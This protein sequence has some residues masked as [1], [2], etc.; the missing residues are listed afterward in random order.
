MKLI[1]Y[2]ILIALF[3]TFQVIIFGQCNMLDQLEKIE[4]EIEVENYKVAKS[5]LEEVAVMC[6]I[7]LKKNDEY[8]HWFSILEAKIDYKLNHDTSLLHRVKIPFD[9]FSINKLK[10]GEK[11][12]NSALLYIDLL[13]EQTKLNIA[14]EHSN[15]LKDFIE[16]SSL[17]LEKEYISC[18]KLL[19]AMLYIQSKYN[20]ALELNKF[21]ES[22]IEEAQLFQSQLYIDLKINQGIIYAKLNKF[23]EAQAE[24]EQALLA[25][26]KLHGKDHYLSAKIL[27]SMGYLSRQAGDTKTALKYHLK[28]VELA[29]KA[30]IIDSIEITKYNQN[31]LT[32]YLSDNKLDEALAI[33]SDSHEILKRIYGNMHPSYAQSVNN[34]GIIYLRKFELE[35]AK[36]YIKEAIKSMGS[37]K[38][39]KLGQYYL[40]LATIEMMNSEYY[41]AEQNYLKVIDIFLSLNIESPSLALYKNNLATLYLNIGDFV[42]AKSL[43]DEANKLY[44]KIYGNNNSAR[45]ASSLSNLGL[46]YYKMQDYSSAEISFQSASQILNNAE[47]L[48]I[49]TYSNLQNNIGLLKTSQGSFNDAIIA[50][51]K[52]IKGFSELQNLGDKLTD[53]Y[54]PYF[55]L[56]EVYRFVSKIDS[57]ILIQSTTKDSVIIKYGKNNIL[58]NKLNVGL[59]RSYFVKNDMEKMR[60]NIRDAY[61]TL[62][63]IIENQTK[64][65][66]EEEILKFLQLFDFNKNVLHSLAIHYDS[67]LTNLAYDFELSFKNKILDDIL[68]RNNLIA[69]YP[70][71]IKGK[72]EQWK[73]LQI[74]LSKSMN[75]TS[76]ERRNNVQLIEE[77]TELE[78]EINV[79]THKESFIVNAPSFE[80]IKS[81]LQKNAA[82]I[83][84]ISYYKMKSDGKFDAYKSYGALILK[85]GME[86]PIPVFLCSE[87]ALDSIIS[88][89][90]SANYPLMM[91]M[92]YGNLKG[93][94]EAQL[95]TLL[96]KP[97]EQHL[98]GIEIIS[99]APIDKLNQ[100]NFSAIRLSRKK[101]IMDV[102]KIRRLLSTRAV[103]KTDFD[104][105]INKTCLVGGLNY[106]QIIENDSSFSTKNQ[107]DIVM[108]TEQNIERSIENQKWVYLPGSAMEVD[109]I[110]QLLSSKNISST[111]LK[112][113]DG[114]EKSFK[115]L[116]QNFDTLDLLHISTHGFYNNNTETFKELM[117]SEQQLRVDE[118]PFLNAGL[119]FSGANKIVKNP[120]N[121]SNFEE[122]GILNGIEVAQMNLD[123]T[124]LVVLS[125]C[126]SGKGKN[127]VNEGNYGMVRAF[128]TAGVDYIISSLWPVPDNVTSELMIEFYK[129]YI[130]NPSDPNIALQTAQKNLRTKYPNPYYWAAFVA[131]R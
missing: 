96:W 35:Q 128:K 131:V 109:T 112:N 129:N 70:D 111:V 94:S 89:N 84:F 42:K 60:E 38:N 12:A 37:L 43:L 87:P 113:K 95:Y 88:V 123:K 2:F 6:K 13:I 17:K 31:I 116:I 16:T 50:F 54:K 106:D 57:S 7:K 28:S 114:S 24:T 101:T 33:A 130:T 26:E 75:Q 74:R 19:V 107:E 34:L 122:D 68:K 98:K 110:A 23:V 59:V 80:T 49:E 41:S 27:N 4:V 86:K 79:A 22:K 92:A 40:N 66:T 10:Y 29:K 78:K 117:L 81:N 61:A 65:N 124:K 120:N 73:G 97:M 100:I 1:R 91:E 63:T 72:Y 71:D 53:A 127:I 32:L 77:A 119:I 85:K 118:N 3:S 51:N 93:R 69:T 30:P 58:L 14:L 48:N 39:E 103:D 55:N 125:A 62:N 126:D 44:K 76:D 25:T 47:K 67:S 45:H 15:H 64:Y 56:G 8:S 21:A 52:A 90:Q 102:F 115:K 99:Y 46:A 104:G 83:E 121:L 105:T 18:L 9:F 36:K 20:E 11:Y 5:L 108:N 82:A